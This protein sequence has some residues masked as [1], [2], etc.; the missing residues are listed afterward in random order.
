MIT[1][2]SLQYAKALFDL[3]NET[4]LENEYYDYLQMVCNI[5]NE[6]K[7]IWKVLSHPLIKLEERK[8]ILKTSFQDSVNEEFLHFLF[9]LIDNFRL[10]EISD[11]LDSYEYYLNASN[12]ICNA[13]VYSKYQ[14]LEEEKMALQKALEGHLNK[15]INLKYQ[16][17]VNLL[18]GMIV[19]IDG[20]VID[21][22]TVNQIINLKNELKKGW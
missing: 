1:S 11:I 15:K 21:A 2:V 6:N 20:K 22:S 3:G 13:I 7:D 4:H 9:V 14:M 8:H 19:N 17:D 5:L 16:L 18:G 12:N 10:E